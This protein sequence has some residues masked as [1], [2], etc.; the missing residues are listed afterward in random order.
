MHGSE[1]RAGC[2]ALGPE[3]DREDGMNKGRLLELLDSMPD[4][5]DLEELMYR[6]YVLQKI[7]KAEASI[8]EYGLI[9]DEDL[10]DAL[11]KLEKWPASAGQ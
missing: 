8:E 3:F 9:A 11:E 10:D 2:V 1:S 4:E 5:I 6:L 7:E